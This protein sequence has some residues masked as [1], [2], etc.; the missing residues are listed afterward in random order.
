MTSRFRAPFRERKTPGR[1]A[2]HREVDCV[3]GSVRKEVGGARGGG[4]AHGE[5]RSQE[6]NIQ[7][8][9]LGFSTWMQRGSRGVDLGLYGAR[10]CACWQEITN[11]IPG[12]G[13]RSAV[14]GLSPDP[15]RLGEEGRALARGSRVAVREG[16]GPSWQ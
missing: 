12:I 2:A 15:S 14:P 10:F 13:L 9:G 6:K 8:L 7:R 16:A 5:I 3:L 4:R 1:R 11:P